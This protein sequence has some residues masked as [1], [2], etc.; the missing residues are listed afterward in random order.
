[1]DAQK[2]AQLLQMEQNRQAQA[3]QYTNPIDKSG[4]QQMTQN[5]PLPADYQ[6]NY[7][8]AQNAMSDRD[9]Q[10]AQEQMNQSMQDRGMGM[11]V[12]MPSAPS[13]GLGSV[14]MG[15]FMPQQGAMGGQSVPMPTV[16]GMGPLSAQEMEYIR[17]LN[18]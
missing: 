16:G 6:Q 17:S 13:N 9:R 15:Q 18:R 12:P 7:Q 5:M 1:M 8:Y 3:R 11:P 14:P 10:I 4:G 2:L